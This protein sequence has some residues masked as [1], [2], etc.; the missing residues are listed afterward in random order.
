MGKL[1]EWKEQLIRLYFKG[2]RFFVPIMK[3]LL[4]WVLL[5]FINHELAFEERY[6]SFWIIGGISLLSAFLPIGS[7]SLFVMLLVLCQAYA[8][9]P[10]LLAIVAAVMVVLYLVVLRFNSECSI[11]VFL[12]PLLLKIQIPYVIPIVLGLIATPVAMLSVATGTV[13]YF[14]IDLMK[15]VANANADTF[16]DPMIL[17]K[18][19]MDSL[20]HNQRMLIMIAVFSCVILITYC[21]RKLAVSF[22]FE[23]G[24]GAGMITGMMGMLIGNT[25]WDAEISITEVL[26]GSLVSGLIAYII[27]FFRMSLDY[28]SVEYVQFEDDEYYYYVRAVPK[29][30]MVVPRKNITTIRHKR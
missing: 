8:F 2:E 20:L 13:V 3:F 18:Y 5:T 6:S 22:A 16:K 25:V 30:K 10:I 23:I 1:L 29:I 4:T 26:L 9:S 17:Y 14:L 24:I 19:M 15:E 28:G 7:I 21:I 12:L 11:V 27:Q